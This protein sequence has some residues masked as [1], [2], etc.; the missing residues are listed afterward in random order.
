MSLK[1]RVSTLEA[2]YGLDR[3]IVAIIPWLG[4]DDAQSYKLVAEA[5]ERGHRIRLI[6]F[7]MLHSAHSKDEAE[8]VIKSQRDAGEARAITVVDASP[9][10]DEQ[11]V[12]AS[13]DG[14]PE[15]A[16]A[17]PVIELAESARKGGR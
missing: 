11:E 1:H 5:K 9:D 4:P 3:E 14:A 6:T 10:A 12:L 13:C 2:R 7:S 16:A 17:R 8:R 15:W